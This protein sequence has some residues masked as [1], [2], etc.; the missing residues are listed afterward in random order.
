MSFKKYGGINYSSNSNYVK[1][2]VTNSDFLNITQ[3]SGQ[4]TNNTR[5]IF[6]T[7]IDLTC[8]DLI[9]TKTIYFCDG[10]SQS[11]A[12]T[13]SVSGSCYGDYLYW[14]NNTSLWAVGSDK[15]SI[16]CGSGQNNQA[17]GSIALGYQAGQNNQTTN[18]ISIGYQAGQ[19]NQGTGTYNAI[20]ICSYA[21][22]QSQ[23]QNAIAIGTY[24]GQT[25]QSND[26]I[27][28]GYSAGRSNM[29]FGSIAIGT[30]ASNNHNTSSDSGIVSIGFHA[31]R[32][33]QKANTIA[34]GSY[35]G[36]NSQGINA[37]A[38]GSGA[39]N[40]NQYDNAI[41]IGFHAGLTT[42]GT[43]AIA[44]GY[45]AGSTNQ[46]LNAIAIGYNAGN[47]DQG[48]SSIAIGFL[49]G[50]TSQHENSI[51]LNASG[52]ALNSKT[53]N[54]FYVDPIRSA[55]FSNVLYYDTTS[56]EITYGAKSFII[57]H[58]LDENKYLVHACLEGPESGVYYRGQG[59][60]TNN[61]S[62]NIKLPNYV[63][64]LASNITINITPIYDPLNKENKNLEV[65]EY[66]NS[67]NSFD[68]YGKNSKFYW[69]VYGERKPLISEQNKDD[70]IIEGNGPYKWISK[71]KAP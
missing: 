50:Q 29:G 42:Q 57:D 31:G 64:K 26:G 11:T 62:T 69:I 51:I 1:N 56:K 58:P 33:N 59:E 14:D 68:V 30:E 4:N 5:E 43:G 13:I 15:I 6:D 40:T 3:V 47:T 17:T 9:N 2:Y 41:A 10:T 66:N 67:N 39:G 24:A 38:I 52:V 44:I 23:G 12:G 46:G 60:I 36:V 32:Y 37:I 16:G 63:S 54:A 20:A 45:N 61:I 53:S 28:I 18:G 48:T 70:V 25:L 22:Q 35:A 55:T 8:H 21:G 7:N 49:A 27:A 71:I 19:N 65:S 34:I